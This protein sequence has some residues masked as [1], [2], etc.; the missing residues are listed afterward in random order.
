MLEGRTT[1]KNPH[2]ILINIH[3][4]Y[5]FFPAELKF[6]SFTPAVLLHEATTVSGTAILVPKVQILV[7][8]AITFC[9]LVHLS[10]PNRF[11]KTTG[12]LPH[13]ELVLDTTQLKKKCKKHLLSSPLLLFCM[14]SPNESSSIS[15]TVQEV[16]VKPELR[17]TLLL[18]F[19]F[20][21]LSE[22]AH[23]TIR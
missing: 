21:D 10:V 13:M 18:L 2:L 11:P 23:R 3:F 16:Q 4:F 20:M 1:W 15:K 19:L 17:S 14:L 5:F 12:R 9:T 22:I 6:P 7:G 8:Q